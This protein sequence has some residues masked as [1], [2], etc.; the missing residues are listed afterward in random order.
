MRYDFTFKESFIRPGVGYS[1][2]HSRT[3]YPANGVVQT[4]PAEMSIYVHRNYAQKTGYLERLTLRLDGFVALNAPFAGGEMLTR[5]LTFSG[6]E[7]EMNYSTSAAGFIRVEIQTPDGEP[8]PG[9]TLAECPR[10]IGDQISR[11]VAWGNIP[12]PKKI[13]DA[14]GRARLVVAPWKGK[15]DLSSLAGKSVRLRFVM[16]DADLFSLKFR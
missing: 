6:K 13:T 12:E 8:I 10:I 15:S 2:W 3:N 14:G 5:P 4:G 16:K 1:H 7:L 11:V 9:Y